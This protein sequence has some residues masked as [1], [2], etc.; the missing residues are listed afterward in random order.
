MKKQ[1]IS[2]LLA[3]VMVLTLFP[4]MAFADDVV[5]SIGENKYCS[6]EDAIAAA[7]KLVAEEA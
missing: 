5:A 1:I 7:V 3:C 6:L 2:I 4:A